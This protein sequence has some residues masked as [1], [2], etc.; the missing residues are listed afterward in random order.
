MAGRQ[1]IS[2][3]TAGLPSVIYRGDY[4]GPVD[5]DAAGSGF[6]APRARC[7][8]ARY[9]DNF[10]CVRT[11][12]LFGFCGPTGGHSG[13]RRRLPPRICTGR[14]TLQRCPTDEPDIMVLCVYVAGDLDPYAHDGSVATSEGLMGL[15]PLL[16]SEPG[17]SGELV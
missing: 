4:R 13:K 11:A 8:W 6:R 2:D 1:I 16:S 12:P 10:S 5:F 9:G 7:R 14:E 3:R 17:P 15:D